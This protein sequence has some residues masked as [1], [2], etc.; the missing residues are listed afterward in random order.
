MV[1]LGRN[2]VYEPAPLAIAHIA[3]SGLPRNRGGCSTG[4]RDN[5]LALHCVFNSRTQSDRVVVCR[6]FTKARSDIDGRVRSGIVAAPALPATARSEESADPRTTIKPT[7]DGLGFHPP[8][9][10]RA[11]LRSGNAASRPMDD[12][13]IQQRP[14][15]SSNR[16]ARKRPRKASRTADP[17]PTRVFGSIHRFVGPVK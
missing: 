5:R 3:G 9:R 10:R 1:S 12:E 17:V 13:V 16:S 15:R 4:N 6:A 8:K 2:A 7:H 11:R 14:R